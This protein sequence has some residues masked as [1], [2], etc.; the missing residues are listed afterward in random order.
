MKRI[1]LRDPT[2]IAPFGEPARDLRILNKPLWL[3]QRDLLARHCQSVLEVD[4]WAAIPSTDE[5]L[6]VHKDNLYFNA[7]LIDTFIHEARAT[8]QPCQVAFA[9]DDALITTHATRLQ[10]SIKKIDNYYV[11]DLY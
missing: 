3:L 5:E 6:L 9:E 1:V 7:A 10:D 4:N 2:L 8:G 11:A